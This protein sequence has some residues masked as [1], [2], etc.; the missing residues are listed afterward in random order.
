MLIRKDLVKMNQVAMCIKGLYL[1]L[2]HGSRRSQ[3]DVFLA[4]SLLTRLMDD[5][6]MA[7]LWALS[8]LLSPGPTSGLSLGPASWP[9]VT[10]VGQAFPSLL[11]PSNMAWGSSSS[12][13]P[14]CT[15][16]FWLPPQGLRS[17][18][19]LRL[20]LLLLLVCP[21]WTTFWMVFIPKACLSVSGTIAWS[22]VLIFFPLPCQLQGL[23]TPWWALRIK[24]PCNNLVTLVTMFATRQ[25][26]SCRCHFSRKTFSIPH[27][28]QTSLL[29]L[30][31][32]L[33]C[34]NVLDNGFHWFMQKL[35]EQERSEQYEHIASFGSQNHSVSSFSSMAEWHDFK[36]MP[37]TD[38][39]LNRLWNYI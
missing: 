37:L 9:E 21:F 12:T 35:S 27:H 31:K 26:R 6:Y 5:S 10:A 7:G 13:A 29:Q 25:R 15:M 14:F 17:I 4:L 3:C 39:R 34:G 38:A 11:C 19:Q 20:P 22:P 16:S 32:W 28:A 18:S 1:T 2:N 36:V 24:E 8:Q 30:S 33:F 23:L